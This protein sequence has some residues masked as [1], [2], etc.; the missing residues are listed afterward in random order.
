MSQQTI[1]T[2]S[3]TINLLFIDDE[4]NIINSLRMLFRRQKNT[5]IFTTTDQME[6]I[7]IIKDN[8][9]HVIVSDMKMP[10][11]LGSE[12]LSRV[13]KI[14]PNTM[15][16]LLSG[17]SDIADILDSIN[18][19][20]VFRFIPKPWDNVNI[21]EKINDAASISSVFWKE[22]LLADTSNGDISKKDILYIGQADNPIY[23]EIQKNPNIILHQAKNAQYAMVKLFNHKDISVVILHAHSYTQHLANGQSHYRNLVALAKLLKSS[24]PT[25]ISIIIA[26]DD[27]SDNA[28]TLINE[29]QIF[30]YLTE[31]LSNEILSKSINEAI[32]YANIL[33]NTPL[34]TEKH[35]VEEM[36]EEIPERMFEE[37]PEEDQQKIARKKGN[38]LFKKLVNLLSFSDKR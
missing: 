17:Y 11:M 35:R 27:D 22:S 36:S 30:R 15:R 9:I 34:L 7:E 24:R 6:A 38:S 10:N 25:L 26:R 14:S 8:Q 21:K 16:I 28:I 3:N 31:P 23:D 5:T 13:R 32:E 20:Q 2:D 33:E 4:V 37:I 19:A 18:D 29:A 12:L 1:E